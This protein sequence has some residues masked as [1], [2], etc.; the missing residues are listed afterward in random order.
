[1][2]RIYSVMFLWLT[3]I[4]NC[5]GAHASNHKQKP[6][7]RP[8]RGSFTIQINNPAA[9]PSYYHLWIDGEGSNSGRAK[10]HL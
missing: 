6:E 5:I 4:G 10:S 2:L 9:K 1:M 7:N 8:A 3:L